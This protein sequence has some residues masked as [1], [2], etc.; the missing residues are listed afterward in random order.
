MT[1]L[2]GAKP[3]GK[4]SARKNRAAALGV[5][6][7]QAD[8]AHSKA[9]EAMQKA[10]VTSAALHK[11]CAWVEREAGCFRYSLPL[12]CHKRAHPDS[13]FWPAGYNVSRHPQ[14]K[15]SKNPAARE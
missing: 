15:Q 4:G 8:D 11:A 2:P 1:L 13:F 9:L 6:V 5:T 7:D 14:C 12:E 3:Q 10:I